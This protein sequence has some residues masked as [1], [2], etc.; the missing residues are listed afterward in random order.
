MTPSELAILLQRGTVALADPTQAAAL[1]FRPTTDLAIEKD[2]MGW[3]RTLAKQTGWEY[4]HTHDARGS[5]AGWPDVA[6]CRPGTLIVAELKKSARDTT[7]QAQS[8]WLSILSTVP[9][10][11]C[12]VWRPQDKPAIEARLMRSLSWRGEMPSPLQWQ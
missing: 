11:E 6:L 7:S 9:G 4:Y 10:I 3:I 1:G 5:A 2:L 8:T 12:Y